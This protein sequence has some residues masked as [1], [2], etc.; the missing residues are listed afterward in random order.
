MKRF[1]PLA[2]HAGYMWNLQQFWSGR[3][4]RAMQ[5]QKMIAAGQK[6]LAILH[7]VAENRDY[8]HK[9]VMECNPW[10]QQPDRIAGRAE[11]HRQR[12]TRCEYSG[13]FAR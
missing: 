3:S 11:A 8:T 4:R 12:K 13:C 1:T 2:V 6:L 7:I 10:L 5:P 9:Q